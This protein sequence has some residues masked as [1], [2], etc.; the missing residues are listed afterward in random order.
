MSVAS[1][2][3]ED[4]YFARRDAA[5]G[6]AVSVGLL[7]RCEWCEETV[8]EGDRTRQEDAY[9]AG[10]WRFSRGAFDGVFDSRREMTDAIK[11]VENE[12][13]LNYC[14]RCDKLRSD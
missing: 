4:E 2:R 12:H 11:E 14:P 10:N 7:R 13:G 1:A 3:A 5:I 6:I 9:R 8:L